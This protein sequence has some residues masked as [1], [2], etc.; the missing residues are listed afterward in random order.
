MQPNKQLRFIL[1]ISLV[2][3]CIIAGIILFKSLDILER[4]YTR[5]VEKAEVVILTS[6]VITDQSWGSLAYKGKLKIEEQ[7]PTNVT[8]HSELK[9]SKLKEEMISKVVAGKPDVIIGHGREFS[10]FFAKVATKFPHI[11][12]VTIHGNAIHSNQ[13]VY[14]FDQDR[15]EYIAGIIA[16]MKTTS[17]KVGLIDA[18]EAREKN[19]G[20]EKG[21][22]KNNPHSTLDYRVVNSR[23]DGEKALQ[24]VKEMIESGVDVVFTKGNGYNKDVVNYAKEKGIYV[25]GYLEDQS[26]MGRDIVL[27]SV[28][29]DVS[30]AYVVLMKDY[31]SEEG[32]SS[33]KKMLDQSDGVYELA[34]LGPMFTEEEKQILQPEIKK[35]SK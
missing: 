25:I 10:A 9:T 6:D 13:S 11:N 16:G 24:I 1:I 21:L 26:Y 5:G 7:Y 8:L 32:L 23:N 22:M 3:I 18:F 27:T 2:A 19:T 20:F 17:N 31:F 4:L 34:P 29:N 12:F 33:G 15:V 28:Q 35:L 30:Q 14:T